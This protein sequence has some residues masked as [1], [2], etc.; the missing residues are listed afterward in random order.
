M[1][2]SETVTE[3]NNEQLQE[4]DELKKRI[5]E[6][7][8][9]EKAV[10]AAGFDIW[11]NNFITGEVYGT[12]KRTFESLG[13]SPEE[14]PSDLEETFKFIHP[15]DLEAALKIMQD[16]LDGKTDRYQ[17]EMRLKAKDGT[18]V[19][20]GNYGRV[21]ERSPEG[22][23]ISFT[24]LSFNINKRRIVEEA[25]L[26]QNRKLLEAVEH[27]KALQG[28]IPICSHCK[29]IRNDKGYWDQVDEYF[30]RHSDVQF[31]HSICPECFS[32]HYRGLSDKIKK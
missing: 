16:H 31:S 18:W 19:W 2:N 3:Q 14:L 8:R 27:I 5:A 22:I 1:K 29:K 30:A 11:E 15:V 17:A 12:N 24:G 23:P 28:I 10:E 26:E 6:L 32:A 20:I 25:L 4:N 21:M 7:E 13:Y 9:I